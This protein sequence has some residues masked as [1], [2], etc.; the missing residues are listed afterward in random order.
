M[1]YF[2][3]VRTLLLYKFFDCE[4]LFE[5]IMVENGPKYTSHVLRE[6]LDQWR[7]Q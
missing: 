3:G 1:Y 6:V 7:K 4:D 5:H 2:I